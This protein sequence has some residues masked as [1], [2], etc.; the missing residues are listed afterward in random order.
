LRPMRSDSQPLNGTLKNENTE[1]ARSAVR[2][3]S[4][5]VFSC[6]VAYVKINA[7]KI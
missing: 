2:M 5:E 1:A 4:R 6:R 3:K 7:V